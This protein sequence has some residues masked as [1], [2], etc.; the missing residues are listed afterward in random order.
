MTVAMETGIVRRTF[1]LTG[2]LQGV[3]FR[4]ALYRLAHE[5]QL[6]GWVQNRSGSVRLVLEG[7]PE[8]V[9]AFMRDL[10][11]RLP[12]HARIDSVAAVA[13]ENRERWD[14]DGF[15]IRPSGEGD[16]PDVLIP[17][18]LA[19]CA[20]CRAEVLNP[21]D[22]RYGY[23][24]T[25]CTRCGPRYTVL[26]AMPYD[27]E[28]TTL[29]RFPLCPACR[30]EYGNPHDRRFHAESMACP[31]CGPRL[32]VENPQGQRLPGNPLR[33]VRQE[34]AA[35]RI[36]AV[37]GLGGFLLAAD[38]FN[39]EAL[40]RLRER[41][42]RPHR[43]LAVMAPDLETVRRYCVTPPE[44]EALLASPEAP[45][46][47]LD[48]RPDRGAGNALPLDAINPDTG[49]L[50]VMLP[51]TPLHLLLFEPLGDDP[52]PRFE[53]LVM[54]SGNKRGEPI[55]IRNDEARV[56]LRGIADVLLLHDREIN[57]R[58]DD[59][60]C[61]VQG[62]TPQIW[63]R[64]RG[65][66]PAPVR[67][68]APLRRTVL[69]MGADMKNALAVGYGDRVVLSPH[70]GDLDTP[71]AL[72]GFEQVAR[73][74]PDFLARAPEVV[75]VDMHPDMQA[76]RLGRALAER[77]GTPVAEVQH[78]HAHAAACL[79]EHGLCEGLAL[80]M[81]GTGWGPD[82]AI[83][84]A[85]LLDIRP[86]G[87]V[88]LATFAP[89]PLPG[90]DMAVRCPARQL[91]GRWAEAGVD[92]S[93]EWRRRLGVTHEEAAI[94]Q[95]QCRQRLNAPLSHAAGR[96]FDAFSI[97]LGVSPAHLTYEGQPAI[98]LEAAVRGYRDGVVPELSY[99][100][101]VERGML[102][103]DWCPVFKGLADPGLT[104]YGA[105]AWALAFHRAIARAAVDMVA[106]GFGRS[107]SRTVAL[108]GG[109]FMNRIL[110][111][112]LAP[113]LETLGARVLRHRRTPPGDGC[114]AAGQA[115]VAGTQQE[116]GGRG[117]EAERGKR[118]QWEVEGGRG[119]GGRR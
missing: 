88:R 51:T 80:V 71:E 112:L 46:V 63:R 95:R 56:R 117:Q 44:A 103:I 4:P 119:S 6:G 36:V 54:T 73:S 110:N 107:A 105:P 10:P 65:Y 62:G 82:G 45:V 78:H 92:V 90:G 28:R 21:A 115:V 57:L 97:L 49:T 101:R 86:D 67:L 12:P 41:K 3:G 102:V 32:T 76:T 18:D 19:M 72:E 98:R 111:D 25:T 77:H 116:S 66:A 69:A 23:P 13:E 30:R 17:A 118:G 14:G 29:S 84:G 109:V 94:W 58:N 108:S 89:A 70:V 33:T 81:D 48:V 1:E 93:V 31:E 99:A 20:D 113:E 114:I 38:A 59:S 83:W 47:I 37:R 26:T 35:G 34:L 7:P 5:A 22:R 43:P 79:A 75:A 104:E 42:H 87:A 52:V 96:V 9:A 24:F 8:T 16:E 61:V 100:T 50:G 60:V 74:L 85:E 64:A 91:I 39:R 2:V 106:Y 11:A 27:R 55:C 15:E 68:G 53:M 40:R